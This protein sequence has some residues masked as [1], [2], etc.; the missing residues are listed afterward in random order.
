MRKIEEVLRLKSNRQLSNRQIACSCLISH[1]TVR[2]Y[3]NRA[4]LAGLSWPLD[5][6]LDTQLLRT[7]FSLKRPLY[8][9]KTVQCLQW[10]IYIGS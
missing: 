3:L 7:C 6:A 4:R 2:E 1:T 5:P 10:I 8:L 9:L